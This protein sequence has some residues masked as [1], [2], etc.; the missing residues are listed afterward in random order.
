MVSALAAIT[1][2]RPTAPSPT[3][4]TVSPALTAALTAG[5]WPVHITSDRASEARVA[6]QWPAPGTVTNVA[7]AEPEPFETQSQV[8]T[9]EFHLRDPTPEHPVADRG[10]HPPSDGDRSACTV[11]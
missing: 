4:A 2:H 11:Q 9:R 7:S 8:L 3:T 5:W 6:S 1:A 10:I